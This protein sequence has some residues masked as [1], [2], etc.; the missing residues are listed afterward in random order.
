MAKLRNRIIFMFTSHYGR[1]II[2]CILMA[3]G[4]MFGLGGRFEINDSYVWDIIF[5][6]GLA[7]M[8]S[9]FFILAYYATI[10]V[11]SDFKDRKNR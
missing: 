6:I 9:Y 7:I 5:Y 4:S 8:L 11:I 3:I 2:S 1:L 10:G